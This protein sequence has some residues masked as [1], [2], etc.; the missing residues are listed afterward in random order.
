V[1]SRRIGWLAW[2]LWLLVMMLLAGRRV[3]GWPSRTEGFNDGSQQGH[4]GTV[5]H[6]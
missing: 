5:T 1:R 3:Y 6:T 4:V 2:L